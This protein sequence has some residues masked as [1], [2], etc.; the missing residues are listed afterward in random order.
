MIGLS[1][2]RLE[3]I[4]FCATVAIAGRGGF[5]EGT[6]HIEGYSC[7]NNIEN[8]N[9]GQTQ[10]PLTSDTVNWTIPN[11]D[12]SAGSCS[13]LTFDASTKMVACDMWLVYL[14]VTSSTMYLK[15]QWAL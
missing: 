11:A 2:S 13:V 4:H 9:A 5:A 14:Q 7:E 8:Q 12:V 6:W 1:R 3:E 10:T 15:D